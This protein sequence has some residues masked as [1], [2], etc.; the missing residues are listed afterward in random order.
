MKPEK[1]PEVCFP[2]PMSTNRCL[3]GSAPATE[4]VQNW[5]DLW[6][7]CQLKRGHR[8]QRQ[9]LLPSLTPLLGA[10]LPAICLP[11][12]Q[13]CPLYTFPCPEKPHRQL[14][15]TLTTGSSPTMAFWCWG[16]LP[17]GTDLS[18]SPAGSTPVLEFLKGTFHNTRSIGS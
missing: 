15:A 6:W 3:F 17:T 13:F 11:S 8:I 9:N 4:R 18:A 1:H 10:T 12:A 5:G 7:V 2:Y 14:V 16:L